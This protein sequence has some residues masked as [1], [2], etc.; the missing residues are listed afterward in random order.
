MYSEERFMI[1]G[2]VAEETTLME[3][4]ELEEGHG[5]ERKGGCPVIKLDVSILQVKGL[6]WNS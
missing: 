2:V 4:K 6:N 5:R 1:G 3:R